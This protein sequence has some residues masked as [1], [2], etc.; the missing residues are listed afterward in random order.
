MF[1]RISPRAL[2]P[3]A[4]EL[5]IPQLAT[6]A[7]AEDLTE[8]TPYT[9]RY[10]PRASDESAAGITI[11]S[12]LGVKTLGLVTVDNTYGNSISGFLGRRG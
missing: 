6:L 3:L 11:A 8:G 12:K 9:F 1:T 7:T 4:A 2:A 10:W 5:H